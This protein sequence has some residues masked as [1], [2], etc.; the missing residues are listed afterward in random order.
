[1]LAC[2]AYILA[3]EKEP[4]EDDDEDTFTPYL[5]ECR[6]L[7]KKARILH[8][9]L[10]TMLFH[11][12][13]E[14]T[15]QEQE[16][17]TQGVLDYFYRLVTVNPF[18]TTFKGTGGMVLPPHHLEAV[19]NLLQTFQR[20]YHHTS[21]THQ[22]RRKIA[23]DFF[24]EFL[25]LLYRN[26]WNSEEASAQAFPKG[27]VPILTIHQA[28]GLEFPVVVVGRLDK[29]FVFSENQK[30]QA[31]QEF[32]L[33]KPFEPA[34]RISNFDLHRLYYVAFSRAKN[35]LVLM[36]VRNPW[37]HIASLWQQ[38]PS[39]S[40]AALKNMPT[41]EAW[42]KPSLPRPRYGL[43]NDLQLYMTCPR[44]FQFFRTYNFIPGHNDAYFSGQ[45]VHHTL[46]H[47]HRMARDRKLAE[48]NDEALSKIFERKFQALTQT[49][50]SSIDSE[51]KA[52]AWQQIQ[53]Y[54]QQNWVTL[55][56][57]EAAELPVQVDTPKYVLTGTIDLLVKTPAGFDLI[58]FKTLPRP[59]QDTPFLERYEQQLHFYAHALEQSRG[60]R[61]CFCIGP[62]K[63]TRKMR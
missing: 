22:K 40:P 2:F 1:M 39:W 32:A 11:M 49:Y 63:N 55:D 47:I 34:A 14:I 41:S 17:E 24:Q 44:Q 35:L 52:Q 9:H 18:L 20:Y 38:L 58:D 60:Q 48:L 51:Q 33:R 45:L 12:R 59:K 31:L 43:T 42:Q 25:P 13:E 62:L 21:V 61:D 7:L 15:Q 46:E 23:H 26:D 53:R 36:A 6:S 27:H 37:K 54:L 28:K 57:V 8:S 30:Y 4:A 19:S 5:D 10:Q 56:R 3:F 29:S 16:I 50:L